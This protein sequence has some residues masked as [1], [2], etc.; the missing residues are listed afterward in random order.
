[1]CFFIRARGSY[2]YMLSLS[3]LLSCLYKL[4]LLLYDD[5]PYVIYVLEDSLVIYVDVYQ[6]RIVGQSVSNP[7]LLKQRYLM[8]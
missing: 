7:K 6:R 8:S 5:V 4:R 3:L 2:F 1:M